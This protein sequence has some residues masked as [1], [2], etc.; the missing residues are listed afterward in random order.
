MSPD[1]EIL[2][3]IS[4]AWLFAALSS[5]APLDEVLGPG[6]KIFPDEAPDSAVPPFVVY[7]LQAPGPDIR[8]TGS[9][10]VAA[11]PLY[12]VRAYA[13]TRSYFGDLL[14][15]AQEVDV[16]LHRRVGSAVDLR[17]AHPVAGFVDGAWREEE[18]RQP[19]KHG[20]ED[21]RAL[22]GFYRLVVRPE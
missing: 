1:A 2:S 16:A 20:E 19:E 14:R 18:F 6:D 10:R 4:D 9:V 7:S 17:P 22:G 3:A 11:R 13:R 8:A 5:H 12:L 21:W 15:A